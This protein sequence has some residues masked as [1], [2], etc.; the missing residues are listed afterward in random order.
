MSVRLYYFINVS[1]VL[2][3]TTV[4]V[5]L[6]LKIKIDNPVLRYIGKISMETYLLHGL[7]FYLL[8]G[9]Y[10][11]L[12]SEPLFCFLS[13]ACVILFASILHPVDN[14]LLRAWRRAVK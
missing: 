3:L 10:Y 12:K 13:L 7:I 14:F 8:R 2:S 6:Q 9:D 1:R 4:I 5:L 11:H